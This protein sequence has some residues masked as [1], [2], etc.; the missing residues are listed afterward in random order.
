MEEEEATTV[1]SLVTHLFFTKQI[2]MMDGI[3]S[4]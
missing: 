2:N 1:H 4:Y 3:I